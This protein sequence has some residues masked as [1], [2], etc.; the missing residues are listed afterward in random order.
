[1]GQQKEKEGHQFLHPGLG[2][3]KQSQWYTEYWNDDINICVRLINII[4]YIEYE[5]TIYIY[6]KEILTEKFYNFYLLN[7][8]YLSERIPIELLPLAILRS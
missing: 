2:G 4:F 5:S 6:L 8:K 7:L 3:V 1:M